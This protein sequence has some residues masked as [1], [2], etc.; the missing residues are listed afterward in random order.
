MPSEHGRS[1][2]VFWLASNGAESG[3]FVDFPI[4]KDKKI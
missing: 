2:M 4:E 3:A 1:L